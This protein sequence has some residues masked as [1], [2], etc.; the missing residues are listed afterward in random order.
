MINTNLNSKG[1]MLVQPGKFT[2]AKTTWHST[3]Y[4][5][6]IVFLQEKNKQTNKQITQK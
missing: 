2:L 3:S 5:V 6:L 1:T 4:F